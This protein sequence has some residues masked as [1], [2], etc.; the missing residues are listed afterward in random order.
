MTINRNEFAAVGSDRDDVIRILQQFVD[1]G[2]SGDVKSALAACARDT[3][4]IDEFPPYVWHGDGSCERWA[5]DFGA[6]AQKNAI[7]HGLV[8]L[9]TPL[10]IDVTDDQA[11]AV[12]RAD[13][14]FHMK[15][16]E[17]K[18]VDALWTVSLRKNGNGWQ[19]TGFA[20]SKS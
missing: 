4:I 18:E 1:S 11:Y 15:E 13:Y 6:H 20:W 3:V 7:A 12:M 16:K 2:T 9:G 19:I 17:I 14:T 8:T 10:H 5:K